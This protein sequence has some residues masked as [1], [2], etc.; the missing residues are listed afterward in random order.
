LLLDRA[1]VLT[2]SGDRPVL[3]PGWVGVSSGRVAAVGTGDPPDAIEVV[4]YSG[5]IIMPGF[6][7]AHAHLLGAFVRGMGGDR[8]TTVGSG[9]D[10]PTAAVRLVMEE[11]D[12]Y[13]A[14]RLALLEMQLSGVT[15]TTDSQP[16]LRGKESQADGTLRALS[17]SG[18]DA[19]FY[20]ASVDRT[21]F[22]PASVHDRADA[23]SSE[24]ARL[25]RIYRGDRLEIGVEP[26]ALHRVTDGLMR[27]LTELARDRGLPLAIHGP[28]GHAAA[29]HAHERWRRS[30][31]EVMA[32]FGTLG[33]DVLVHHPV[34]LDP[35]DIPI[36]AATDTAT[37]ACAVDNLL[38]GTGPAPVPELLDAG[39]RVGIGLDQPNDGHDMFQLMKLTMLVQRGSGALWGSPELMLELATAGGAM[40]LGLDTGVIQP[41][42]WADL[43]VLDGRHPTLQ[44][45][46]AAVSNLVLA[47]GPQS[48]KAVYT[49]GVKTVESGR[50]LV[51]DQDE[52]IDAADAAMRRC[53]TRAGLSNESWSAWTRE[54]EEQ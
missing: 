29:T 16:A 2:M 45:R 1:T 10:R 40:A 26:M 22:F 19:V 8:S 27:H 53:L 12:A 4:D 18:V 13:A 17:E 31:I 30:A 15:A 44:P 20:R 52:V 54:R 46:H 24:V 41:D 9:S 36:L 34:V 11:E 37:S 32:E 42:G 28:Y 48:I 50:H 43:V 23:A 35:G 3:D 7:N 14:A 51:W 5:D 25:S 47:A 33:P 6:V 39:V 49:R 38:I 21:D